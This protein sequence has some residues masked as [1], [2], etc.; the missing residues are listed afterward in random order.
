MYKIEIVS[1][2]LNGDM[3]KLKKCYETRAYKACIIICGLILETVMLNWISEKENSDYFINGEFVL[4]KN[5][6]DTP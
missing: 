4:L 2:L 6:F 1:E 5:I 3:S